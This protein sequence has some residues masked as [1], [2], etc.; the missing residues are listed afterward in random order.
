MGGN[1]GRLTHQGSGGEGWG[2]GGG[3]FFSFEEESTQIGQNCLATFNYLS[4]KK[5]KERERK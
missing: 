2:G 3:F 5:K 4:K 1:R